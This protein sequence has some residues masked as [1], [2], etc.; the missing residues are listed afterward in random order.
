MK[1]SAAGYWLAVLAIGGIQSADGQAPGVNTFRPDRGFRPTGSYSVAQTESV[2]ETNGNVSIRIPLAKTSPGRNGSA[3]DLV[4]TYN[5][6][7]FNLSTQSLVAK[8]Y[9]LS[10]YAGDP[11]DSVTVNALAPSD[12]A[13][14]G[15]WR[16]SH[17]YY[18]EDD[19]RPCS[20]NEPACWKWNL[21]LPDGSSHLLRLKVPND[22]YNDP[23]GT[24]FS[25]FQITGRHWQTT[26]YIGPN[27]VYYTTDGTFIRVEATTSPSQNFDGTWRASFP[28]GDYVVGPI[29]GGHPKEADQICD[30]NDN[31]TSVVNQYDAQSNMTATEIIG[32]LAREVVIAYNVEPNVDEIKALGY[33]ADVALSSDPRV[34]PVSVT[35]RVVWK[36]ISFGAFAD[37]GDSPWRG[38]LYQCRTPDGLNEYTCTN[39]FSLRVV[40]KIVLPHAS[41]ALSYDF[42]YADA[43]APL[44][45]RGQGEIREMILPSAKPGESPRAK[46]QYRWSRREQA[47]P[48]VPVSW[49]DAMENPVQTKTLTYLEESDAAPQPMSR[50]W[51]YQIGSQHSEITGP[52]NGLTAHDYGNRS[53]VGSWDKGLV[54]KTVSP[55]LGT[56]WRCWQKN[57]PWLGVN[58]VED[59]RNPYVATE[60]RKL[61]DGSGRIAATKFDYDKNGNPLSRTEY[62]WVA[63][64]GDYPALNCAPSGSVS[65]RTEQRYWHP[66]GGAGAVLNAASPPTSGLLN[67]YWNPGDNRT[68]NTLLETRLYAP[69]DANPKAVTQ[70]ECDDPKSSANITR[71]LRWDNQLPGGA[72]PPASPTTGVTLTSSSAAVTVRSYLPGVP[73]GVL[74]S[75]TDP[76]LNVTAF[77]YGQARQAPDGSYCPASYVNLY[78]DSATLAAGRPEA[79]VRKYYY[80]CAT[81]LPR[82]VVFDSNRSL[83]TSFGYDLYGRLIE[84]IEASEQSDPAKKRKTVTQ[85]DDLN[86][87]VRVVRDRS[88]FNDG[89][90]ATVYHFSQLGELYLQRQ[91]D[92]S[93]GPVSSSG[94]EGVKTV[95]VERTVAGTGRYSLVSNPYRNAASETTMGWALR[96]FDREGRLTQE[97]FYKGAAKPAPFGSSGPLTG[98]LSYAHAG[99][100]T[101]ITESGGST[102]TVTVDAAGRIKS[103]SAGGVG[104]AVYDYDVFDNLK[105]VTQTDATTYLGVPPYPGVKTQTRQFGYSSLGRLIWAQNPESGVAAYEYYPNGALKKQQD[106][107]GAWTMLSVDGLNRV[108]GK[109]YGG[110][111]Q[112]TP[113]AGFCY[114]GR[115]YSAAVG[116]CQTVPGRSDYAWGA[117]SGF[118]SKRTDGTLVAATGFSEIDALGRVRGS[119][120][121][122]QALDAKTFQYNYN[123]GDVL[124]SIRYPSG[125]WITYDVTGANRVALVRKGETGNDYYLSG[126]T[127]LPHGALS[128]ATM[129]QTASGQNAFTESREYNSRLQWKRVTAAKGSTLL[130]LTWVYSG[131][132]Q[133]GTLEEIGTDNSGNVRFERIEYPTR[134]ILRSYGYDGASRLTSFVEDTGKSQGFGYDAFGNVWQSSV[135]GVRE[136][137]PN[138]PNWYLQQAAPVAGQVTNRLNGVR[139]TAAGHQE[140]FSLYGGPW[141]IR[142]DAEGRQQKIERTDVTPPSVLGDYEYDAEG[143]RV[144]R[145]SNGATTYYVYDARGLLM[146]EYGGAALAS[147]TRYVVTDHLGSTRLLLDE[148]GTCKSRMDYAP[149]GAE[150]ER[151]GEPCYT[152][153]TEI[154]QKFTGKERDMETGLDYF[155]AR[156]FSGAQGRFT[157]PDALLNS[158]RPWEP[159]SWN[160]YAYAL[161]NPLKYVDPTGLYEWATNCGAGDEQCENNR[162]RFREAL[163]TTRR[164]AENLKKRSAERKKLEDILAK[165]GTEGEKNRVFIAFG[166]A[167]GSPAQEST[168]TFGRF[169]LFGARSRTITFDFGVIDKSIQNR[170]DGSN[171]AIE[172][173]AIVSHEGSHLLDKNFFGNPV[174]YEGSL[175]AER[176]AFGAQSYVNQGLNSFSAWGL[177]NPS[178]AEADKDK[179]RQAAVERE[180]KRDADSIWKKKGQ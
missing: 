20:T 62:D 3:F 27:L 57:E 42:T 55:L 14:A 53:L 141:T 88:A 177:W 129:G 107:R 94:T 119:S 180:A 160:R 22:A 126:V 44:E 145:V 17:R 98:Q 91:T 135:N 111:A 83:K 163:E 100:T 35:T 58:A 140:Q 72:S 93:G 40:D 169:G 121:T 48:A 4:L 2:N 13:A 150:I 139:Y 151:V 154:A 101:T 37:S 123:V 79:Q 116:S 19:V 41:G 159:Q 75:E 69:D 166:D 158:G 112:P 105:T 38:I 63:S 131:S 59:P 108:T 9:I 64:P 168:S 173:G 114:D 127:Y 175:N 174:S 82:H 124:T 155:G 78:P 5:S 73:K 176:S 16:Y 24:G 45:E 80:D 149:F 10:G 102:R 147:G 52:D 32:S 165:Y 65:R 92:D 161:N 138:G 49:F 30:R 115:V 70:F 68:R 103:A 170:S 87:T 97:S 137:V 60:Y 146:A 120:H 39:T 6:A 125:R 128:F 7:L 144:K 31:C 153:S 122:I 23:A 143:R 99:D 156:Y 71:E 1:R 85:F 56:T 172:F 54:Y 36:Y 117:M 89:L 86:R 77:T 28:S 29:I 67:A 162:K 96:T 12:L 118:Y 15:G 148:T 104:T 18:L 95:S 110:S 164:A 26:D 171:P 134:T 66:V 46:V 113:E 152:S 179:L 76:S 43:S 167:G 142:Y 81:G 11:N 74:L 136:L 157:S 25:Q 90:V 84:Q 47:I 8:Q 50:A 61:P 34:N 133:S 106:A 130:G 178:W 51:A 109:T 33:G 21:V 132:F